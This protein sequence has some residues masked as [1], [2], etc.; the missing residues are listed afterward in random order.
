M[1]AAHRNRPRL[2]TP[3]SLKNRLPAIPMGSGFYALNIRHAFVFRRSKFEPGIPCLTFDIVARFE[4]EN[5]I[6]THREGILTA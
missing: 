6:D 5:I 3:A 2:R 1:I 4:D